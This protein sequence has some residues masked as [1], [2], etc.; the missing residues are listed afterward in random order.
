M[1]CDFCQ[2]VC[3]AAHAVVCNPE[4]SS[5]TTTCCLDHLVHHRDAWDLDLTGVCV[6]L[7]D[8]IGDVVELVEELSRRLL[9]SPA[10]GV[11][12]LVRPFPMIEIVD[13]FIV[14]RK[15]MKSKMARRRDSQISIPSPKIHDE[16]AAAAAAAAC[17]I[18]PLSFQHRPFW[19]ALRMNH[20]KEFRVEQPEFFEGSSSLERLQELIEDD[21]VSGEVNRKRDRVEEST[22]KSIDRDAT[23]NALEMASSIPHLSSVA[24]DDINHQGSG[25]PV[26]FVDNSCIL[27]VTEPCRRNLQNQQSLLES[28]ILGSPRALSPSQRAF[29]LA[30][31]SCVHGSSDSS[32]SL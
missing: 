25:S 10:P 22:E 21:S 26:A 29:K 4:D 19:S 20:L 17:S 18:L 24:E 32:L 27:N 23:S 7:N 9:I 16:P 11:P 12:A 13:E 28:G 8:Y 1:R 31:S 2:H 14:Q 30:N 15:K 5:K 3:H 6:Y